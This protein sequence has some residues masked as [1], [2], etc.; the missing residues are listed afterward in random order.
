MKDVDKSYSKITIA[1]VIDKL[2]QEQGN[3]KSSGGNILRVVTPSISVR[4]GKFGNYIFYKTPKMKKPK[5]VKLGALKETF[6]TC[7]KE[8]LMK[9]VEDSS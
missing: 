5:F 9:L 7:S 3:D 6:M 2:D 1:D 8:T 4:K